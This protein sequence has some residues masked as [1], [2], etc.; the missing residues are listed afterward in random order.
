MFT[1]FFFP[2]HFMHG[3]ELPCYHTNLFI[4][5][6]KFV[7]YWTIKGGPHNKQFRL[8]G[9]IFLKRIQNY[10]LSQSKNA[11]HSPLSMISGDYKANLFQEKASI[12]GR[13]KY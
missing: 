1:P 11:F 12:I 9:E 5:I 10:I 13:K 6:H 3:K 7:E 4:A 2:L 8:C